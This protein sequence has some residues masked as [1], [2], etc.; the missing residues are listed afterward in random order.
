[1]KKILVAALLGVPGLLQA[2]TLS[3]MRGALQAL[4][5]QT[6]LSLRVERHTWE[7]KDGKDE[8]GH[9]NF[10]LEDGPKGLRRTDGKAL[11][12]G[13]GKAECWTRA[14]L[15]LL[16][17]LQL[18]TVLDEKPDLLDGRPVRRLRVSLLQSLDAQMGESGKIK[19]KKFSLEMT[20]WV[21]PEN[22]PLAADKQ[23]EMEG[24]ATFL[25]TFSSKGKE[26]RRYQRIKDRLVMVEANQEAQIKAMG[27]ET[28]EREIVRCRVL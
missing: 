1:M 8:S 7:R 19:F 11:P 26:Y 23:M 3:D 24:K 28:I 5:G 4:K 2:D 18:A 16:E 20:F 12:A 15:E 22:L 17:L 21:G 6:P 14:H 25:L 10:E 9:E 27:K 13:E